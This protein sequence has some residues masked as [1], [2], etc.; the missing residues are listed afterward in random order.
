MHILEHKC[1]PYQNRKRWLSQNVLAACDFDMR[2]RFLLLGW[3]RSAHDGRILKDAIDGKGFVVP[4]GKYWLADA[5]YSNSNHLLISYKGVRYHLKEQHL[6][7]QCLWN[8]KEL[9]NLRYSSLLERVF[10]VSKK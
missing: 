5:G 8:P 1:R 4:E 9:F 2:F 10:G 6:A 3:E 7:Q